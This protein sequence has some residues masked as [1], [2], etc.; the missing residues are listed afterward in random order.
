MSE[1]NN[2]PVDRAELRKSIL[3]AVSGKEDVISSF[4][5]TKKNKIAVDRSIEPRRFGLAYLLWSFFGGLFF[6]AGLLVMTAATVWL[7]SNY[8]AVRAV[9]DVFNKLAAL[10]QAMGK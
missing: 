6:G 8:D 3:N 9:A 4:S 2:T 1:I 10:L 5:G 7:I